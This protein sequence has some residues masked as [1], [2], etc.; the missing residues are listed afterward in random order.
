MRDLAGFGHGDHGVRAGTPM[1]GISVDTCWI[2]LRMDGAFS[3]RAKQT[4]ELW[5]SVVGLPERFQN[6]G[7]D[8]DR[9]AGAVDRGSEGQHSAFSIQ[10]EVVRRRATLLGMF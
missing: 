6:A 8:A 2:R 7:A 3:D 1:V 9:Q 4:G 5:A 10:W